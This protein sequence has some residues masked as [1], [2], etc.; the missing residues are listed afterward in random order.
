MHSGSV[1]MLSSLQKLASARVLRDDKFLEFFWL[2]SEEART[3]S[4]LK[5]RSFPNSM[6][7][8]LKKQTKKEPLVLQ[9]GKKSNSDC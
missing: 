9:R 5:Q 4:S 7:F 1:S 8:S 2:G 6:W 3:M